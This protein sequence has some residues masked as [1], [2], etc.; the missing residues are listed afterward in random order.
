MTISSAA[1]GSG[2]GTRARRILVVD[3]NRDAAESMSEL[4]ELLGAEAHVAY[5]GE[6]ALSEVERHAPDVVLLDI[7][8]PDIDGYEVARRIRARPDPVSPLLVAVTG[9]GHEDDRRRAREAGFDHHLV[10]PADVERLEAL[11]SSLEA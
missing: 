9:W 5:D 11:L 7:G 1:D 4:L 2:T 6:G 10:K 8:L 3:D